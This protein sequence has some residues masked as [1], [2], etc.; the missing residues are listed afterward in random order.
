M[1]S[2]ELTDL[3]EVCYSI[4]ARIVQNPR[5]KQITLHQKPMIDNIVEDYKEYIVEPKRKSY[6]SIPYDH[7]DVIT[8]SAPDD[9]STKLWT[10]KCLKLG[11]RLNYVAV[12]TRPDISAA[13]SFCMQHVSGASE[14][15][16]RALIVIVRYV[17]DTSDYAITYGATIRQPFRDYLVKH[18]RKLD[19]DVAKN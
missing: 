4:G 16:F 10:E 11:G 8:R 13:L 6:R 14:S 2:Y 9:P 1:S 12:F 18:S 19:E 15:L 7:D 17:R 3:G 5:L